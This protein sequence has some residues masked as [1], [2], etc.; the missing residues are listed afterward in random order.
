MFCVVH[1]LYVLHFNV[2]SMQ[3]VKLKT[4]LKTNL[5]IMDCKIVLYCVLLLN[6]L[7]QI[8]LHPL[9]PHQWRSVV[10]TGPGARYYDGPPH[11][12]PPDSQREHFLTYKNISN[13]D[14]AVSTSLSLG[15]YV[16]VSFD[17]SR[18]DRTVEVSKLFIIWHF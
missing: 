2:N 4:K 9:S 11:L 12:P 8:V 1:V 3:Y 7:F 15:R 18:H 5:Q 6:S 16:Q 14:F 10:T 17:I 13:L